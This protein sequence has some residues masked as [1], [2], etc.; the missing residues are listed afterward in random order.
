VTRIFFLLSG[1]HPTLPEAEIKAILEAENITYKKPKTSSQVLCLDA[2]EDAVWA[3]SSRSGLT[4]ICGR[5]IFACEADQ[6]EIL[7]MSKDASYEEAL[8]GKQ[9]FAVAVKRVQRSA[10]WISANRLKKSIGSVISERSGGTKV[11][12]EAP[13][14]VFLGVITDQSFIFGLELA[15]ASYHSFKERKLKNRPFF[16]PSALHPKLA[17]CMVNLAR[18]APGSLVLDPFCGTGSILIE[19]GLIGC[20]VLGADVRRLMVNGSLMNLRRF[21]IK[22]LALIVS[23]ALR[24][25]FSEVDCVVTDPPYGRRATTLG[26]PVKDLICQFLSSLDVLPRGG[27]VSIASPEDVDA[28]ELGRSVGFDVVERHSVYVH[29]SLTRE[30]AVLKKT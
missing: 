30:L 12:L 2:S 23:D 17:R 7:R 18:A 8:A 27:Y 16:H 21:N 13:G 10:P 3:V 6:D 4:K 5:E 20:R 24:L 15:E 19:A 26:L 14:K 28:S 22:P 1:E 29:K 11:S 25:P 9:T